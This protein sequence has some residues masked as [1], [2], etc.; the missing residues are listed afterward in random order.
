MVNFINK[1]PWIEHSLYRYLIEEIQQ[2][3]AEV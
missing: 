1:I 2:G 3:Y